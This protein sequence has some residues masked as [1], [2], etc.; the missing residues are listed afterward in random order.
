MKFLGPS[1]ALRCAGKIRE[2]IFHTASA[3]RLTALS[4]TGPIRFGK[5]FLA[6]VIIFAFFLSVSV[7]RSNSVIA[8]AETIVTVSSTDCLTPKTSWDLA[9]SACAR[10][11]GAP[12]GIRR[13]VWVAPDGTVTQVAPISSDPATDT[14][15]IPS[16]GQ[17]AQVGTWTV[18]TVDNRGVGHVAA[19]F[20]VL[21][22]TEPNTDIAI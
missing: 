9:Q 10:V 14:Y 17:F 19:T 4:A 7:W 11:T 22:P 12:V 15:A 18:K 6:V 2:S 16:S 21:S 1:T 20:T 13:F 8:F 3:F 5:S